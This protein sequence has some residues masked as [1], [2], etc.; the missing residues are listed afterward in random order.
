MLLKLPHIA[1][2]VAVASA[3]ANAPGATVAGETEPLAPKTIFALP[4]EEAVGMGE[5]QMRGLV[6]HVSRLDEPWFAVAPEGNPRQPGVVV[7]VDAF[8]RLPLDGSLVLVTGRVN[9]GGDRAVVDAEAVDVIRQVGL[10]P[11]PGIKQADFRR[12]IL[13]N[14]R[15][16]VYGTVTDVKLGLSP[17]DRPMTTLALFIDDYTGCVKV[18]GH[19]DPDGLLDEPIRLTGFVRNI[20]GGNGVFLDAELEL[21][22]PEAITLMRDEQVPQALLVLAIACGAVSL[23]FV[24]VF[25]TLW[26]RTLRERRE[27]A[28]IAAE[29][30]RMAADLHDTIEQHLAGANLIVAGVL[31]LKNVPPD[32]VEAMKS[33]T[34]ILVNAKA[35]VKSAVLDLRSSGMEARSL[36]DAIAAAEASLAKS[37]VKSKRCLRGLPDEL[38]EALYR[39]LLLIIREATTNAVKHGRAKSVVFTS[40]P[41]GDGGFVLRVLNDGAPFDAGRALGP[42]TGHYGLSGMRERA[43]RH[44]VS[45]EWGAEGKWTYVELKVGGIQ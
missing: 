37:G 2:L 14:R 20:Y 31:A 25:F 38:P 34:G 6:T 15:V 33:L 27:L 8:D 11:A 21:E 26:M 5:C 29:R 44:H 39:D 45:I 3:G 43:M 28:V 40:D 22:G 17:S 23:V 42:D 7:R 41:L 24:A 13:A 36:A 10:P 16:T 35:E 18:P 32:V 1:V 30:R 4:R 9:W 12:G 19:M